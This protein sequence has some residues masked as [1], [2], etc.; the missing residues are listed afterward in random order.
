MT[1]YHQNLRNGRQPKPYYCKRPHLDGA[2]QKRGVVDELR[3]VAPKKPNSAKRK[4]VKLTLVNG[5][6]LIAHIPGSGFN[7]QKHSD[8][9]VRSGRRRDLPGVHYHIIRGKLDFTTTQKFDRHNR[10]SKF[11]LKRVFRPI[12]EGPAEQTEEEKRFLKDSRFEMAER[13]LRNKEY[14]E[15]TMVKLSGAD[16]PDIDAPIYNDEEGLIY[17]KDLHDW[18]ETKKA[19]MA[20]LQESMKQAM[21]QLTNPTPNPNDK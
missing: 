1:T 19:E 9:L 17:L 21:M 11:G 16:T 15:R 5:K 7:V 10:R 12:D 2:P 3:I 14:K 20:A 6:S 8:V 4:V 13:M 18:Q